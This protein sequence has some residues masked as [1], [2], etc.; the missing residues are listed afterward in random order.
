MKK[1]LLVLLVALRFG[2]AEKSIAA[3]SGPDCG[4]QLRSVLVRQGVVFASCPSGLFRASTTGKNWVRLTVD[5]RMPLDGFFAEAAPGNPSLYYY[6]PK[7]IGR[8]M[9]SANRKTFGLYRSDSCGGNWELLSTQYDIGDMYVHEDKT[10]YAIAKIIEKSERP[11]AVYNRIVRSTDSG[12]HWEDI[13]HGLHVSL[14]KILQDP[15][16]KEL[17]CLLSNSVQNYVEQAGDKSYQWK[18]ASEGKWF[19]KH[20]PLEFFFADEYGT[21]TTLFMHHATLSNY[22][23]YPFGSRA[24][25]YSFRITVGGGRDFKR[26]EPIVLPVEILFLFERDASATLLDTEK[27]HACWGVNRILPDGTQQVVPIAKGVGRNSPDVRS[28]R[29]THRQSYRRSLDLSAMCDFSMPGTYRV[30]LLYDDG[31]I[32]DVDRGD[33]QGNFRSPVFEVRISR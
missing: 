30:Q 27:G 25:I 9:P 28:H 22:F 4:E 11:T 14:L 31:W 18:H 6:T 7:W 33:W 15:D 12:R 2:C 29:L 21:G 1:L 20:L 19:S 8:T 23:D 3:A 26:K 16:H 32:A 10:I 13:S 5:D 24:E 17:V